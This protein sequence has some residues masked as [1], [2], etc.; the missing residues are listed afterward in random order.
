[1]A[2]NFNTQVN[3]LYASYVASDAAYQSPG[4]YGIPAADVEGV[5]SAI[6]VSDAG[7]G[8]TSTPNVTFSGGTAGSGATASARMKVLTAAVNAAGTG[9][10]PGDTVTLTV[11]GGTVTTRPIITV[12]TAKLVSAT[13]AAG[14][15]GYGN[16]QTFNATVVGGTQTVAAQVNVTSNAGGQITTVNSVSTAGSYTVLPTLAGA[17]TTGGSGTGLTL[18]LVFGVNTITISTAGVAS[19][20]GTAA[21]Q[22]ATSGSGTGLTLNTMTWGVDSVVVTAGGTGYKGT[23]PTVN[24]SSGAAA[25]TAVIGNLSEQRLLTLIETVAAYMGSCSSVSEVYAARDILRQM[26]AKTYSVGA[27]FNASTVKT[28]VVKAGVQKY[29]TQPRSDA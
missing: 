9:Y 10:A 15:S 26:L 27:A 19:V 21:T 25:A 11:T 7:T 12:A 3:S 5:I 8:Y 24:F 29:A 1:M 16:A 22:F 28:A 14:G 17:A 6:T 18:N 20:V 13:I 4:T 23:P 2:I